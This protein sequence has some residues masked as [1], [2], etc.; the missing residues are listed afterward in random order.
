MKKA[1][2]ITTAILAVG[3]L[4]AYCTAQVMGNAMPFGPGGF[5][6]GGGHPLRRLIQA[7]LGRLMT[8]RAELNVTDDQKSRIKEVLQAHRSEILPVATQLV[9]KRRALRDAV[10]AEQPDEVQIRAR[11]DELGKAIGDAAVLGAS[12]IPEVKAVLTPE[13]DS[14]IDR[15]VKDKD[16]S[17]D[18][19]LE[20]MKE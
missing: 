4:A 7:N 12:L 18:N 14:L 9:A 2:I 1:L 8:L 13:Q 16:A 5:G 17:V 19:V 20:D 11:A 15:F 3:G 6:A 10:R